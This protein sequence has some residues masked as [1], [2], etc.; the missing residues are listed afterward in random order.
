MDFFRTEGLS[1]NFGGVKALQSLDMN[2]EKGEIP[3]YNDILCP[4]REKL[5][6]F[7]TAHGIQTRPF[8]PDLN[9][10]PYFENAGRFP[11]SEVFGIQ[12]LCLPSGPDQSI[13][14]IEKVIDVLHK[15]K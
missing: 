4:N 11:N 5:I 7:L 8:Y 6:K 14:N 12:G 10:A 1:I 15:F 3:I 13:E 9:L 2:I